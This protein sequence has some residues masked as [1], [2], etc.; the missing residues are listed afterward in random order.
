MREKKNVKMCFRMLCTEAYTREKL[1]SN[2]IYKNSFNFYD[3][4]IIFYIIFEHSFG[5]D[6]QINWKNTEKI[7]MA[8]AQG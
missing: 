8:P 1:L 6:S 2:K 4:Y 7:S 3:S 5:Y